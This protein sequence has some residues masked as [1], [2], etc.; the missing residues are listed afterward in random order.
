MPFSDVAGIVAPGFFILGIS[1]DQFLY[2]II[3]LVAK[4]NGWTIPK[5]KCNKRL[6]FASIVLA[7]KLIK[8]NKRSKHLNPDIENE[9]EDG[10]DYLSAITLGLQDQLTPL[11]SPRGARAT[12]ELSAMPIANTDRTHVQVQL[13]FEV[14]PPRTMVQ[15]FVGWLLGWQ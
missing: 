2:F 12:I 3:I 10:W 4:Y 7:T 15:R 8:L 11:P 9:L 6:F 13:G 5:I 14:P 1:I